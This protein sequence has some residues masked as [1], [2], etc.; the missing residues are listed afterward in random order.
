METISQTRRVMEHHEAKNPQVSVSDLCYGVGVLV[1][2][3]LILY[4]CVMSWGNLYQNL[5]L[6]GLNFLIL[7]GGI[8]IALKMYSSATK[9]KIDYFTGIKI[10]LRI[11]FIGVLPFVLFIALYLSFDK[12]F[13]QM[14]QQTVSIGNYLNPVTAAGAVFIEGISSGAVITFCA[15]QYFKKE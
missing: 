4:F 13:M 1:F 7:L 5:M 9:D 10:G 2:T 12:H 14:I 15:M 8:L 11:T 6:R 3:C